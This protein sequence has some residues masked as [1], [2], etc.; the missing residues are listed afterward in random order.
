MDATTTISRGRS[1]RICMAAA[2][3][4]AGIA[5]ACSAGRSSAASDDPVVA[6]GDDITLRASDVSSIVASLEPAVRLQLQGHPAALAELVKHEVGR[7]LVLLKA[8]A[9]G[10]EQR[11]EIKAKL[12]EAREEVLASTYLSSVTAPEAAFPTDEQLQLAYTANSS[13]FLLPRQYH[14]A[15]IYIAGAA[16]AGGP[17]RDGQSEALARQLARQVQASPDSFAEVARGSSEDKSSAAKYGDLGWLAENQI[18]PQVR[19]VVEGLP[20]GS[21]SAPIHVSGGWLIVRLIDTKPAVVANF[22]QVK[23][24]LIQLLRK[25]KAE[26]NARAYMEKL[27]TEQHAAVDEIALSKL[28]G[29]GK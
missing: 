9:S 29:T 24:T 21:A 3:F 19:N 17:S 20:K 13:R 16:D 15:Q 14:L 27:M 26:Q 28:A 18:D 22:E 11:P 8:Q 25:Q 5:G 12:Q 10:W 6:K 2:L 1:W 23:P 7:R 4:S